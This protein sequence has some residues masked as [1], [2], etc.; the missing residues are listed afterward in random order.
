M[1]HLLMK[2]HNRAITGCSGFC[3]ILLW[4]IPSFLKVLLYTIRDTRSSPWKASKTKA[5]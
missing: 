2:V 3:T 5:K 4:S 1:E